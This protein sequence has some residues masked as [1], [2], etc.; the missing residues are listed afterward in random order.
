MGHWARCALLAVALGANPLAV[1]ARAAGGF[2]A[3]A[4]ARTG[5]IEQGTPA[6]GS[7]HGLAGEGAPAQQAPRLA[8][9]NPDY[10]AR[11][12]AAFAAGQRA[13]PTMA[14]IARSLTPDQRQR[15][16]DYFARLPPAAAQGPAPTGDRVRGRA[17]AET[18]DW[19]HG[20][21][22]CDACHGP[23]GLGVGAAMPPLRGQGEAYL[24]R[25]LQA[26]RGGARRGD[27]L[28]LMASVARRLSETD[29]R[30]AAAYY[31]GLTAAAPAGAG[32]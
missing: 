6:C 31:A 14:T 4:V 8:G 30:A 7:C 5:R 3:A 32:R 12:L 17:L 22:A 16:A 18:G 23:G 25:Q 24:L 9:L 2:D 28:G 19:A 10:L 11:Q 15:M 1:S 26:F 20:V 13:N 29:L 21:P 27:G